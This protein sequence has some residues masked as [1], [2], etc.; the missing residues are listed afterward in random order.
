VQN[1]QTR[2]DCVKNQ[3]NYANA[4]KDVTNAYLQCTWA[5][6]T[7]NKVPV[8]MHTYALN[9]PTEQYRAMVNTP[10]P[11]IIK[12]QTFKTALRA[13]LQVAQTVDGVVTTATTIGNGI[14][15]TAATIQNVAATM[16]NVSQQVQAQMAPK[17][18]P[19]TKS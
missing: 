3:A 4:L 17:V 2:A 16:A 14:A 18:P 8:A 7:I 9:N 13:G 11:G 15:T 1:I 6:V 19:K 12:S 5:C 10:D